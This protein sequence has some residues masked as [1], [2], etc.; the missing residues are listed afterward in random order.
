MGHSAER[1]L[2][3]YYSNTS[4][5]TT[6]LPENV[7]VGLLQAQTV[8]EFKSQGKIFW[9]IGQSQE[10]FA[11]GGKGTLWKVTPAGAGAVRL[12]KN[13]REVSNKGDATLG[14]NKPL[15]ISYEPDG[16]IL[17]VVD[18]SI[19]YRYGH[20]EIDS[21]GGS[22][23]DGRCMRL[24]SEVPI[25]D[26]LLGIA[27]V[28]A[29]WPKE[30][31][32]AQ[33]IIART[34]ASHKTLTSGKHREPCDCAVYDSAYDQVYM[35]WSRKAAA[36]S[37]WEN[38]RRAVK[39]TAGEVVLHKGAPILALYMSSSGGHT[40]DNENVWGGT[41]L[42]YLRGV[43]DKPDSTSA[44]SNHEWRIAM[45]RSAFSAKLNAYFGTGTLK[46]F[47]ILRPLG[48]SGRVTVVTG[49]SGGVRIVGSART[50]RASGSQVK[51]ALGLNDTLFDVTGAG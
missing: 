37:Y 33:A 8:M 6:K 38:W 21:Y 2:K 30:S 32:R 23:A 7:R 49:N 34:Y 41:P 42:P 51:T 4:V 29:S 40:E 5:G 9:S 16:A 27:E 11:T 39:S 36:G 3:H 25:E 22:C 26:Y 28:S 31:L 15:V 14:G 10:P 45:S 19:R 35:G 17:E 50:V 24:V 46:K 48:A 12:F 47:E 20:M 43:P 1:I 18:E 44:N 13:G